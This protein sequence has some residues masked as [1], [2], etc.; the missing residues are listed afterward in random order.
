VILD[1]IATISINDSPS[2]WRS[3]ISTATPRISFLVDTACMCLRS[4][5]KDQFIGLFSWGYDF[6]R[7]PAHDVLFGPALYSAPTVSW[8]DGVATDFPA[9]SYVV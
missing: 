6:E 1:Q 3:H 9:Y 8:K 5:K 2:L 4:G 7:V